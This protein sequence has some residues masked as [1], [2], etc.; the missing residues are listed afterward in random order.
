MNDTIGG[1]TEWWT[2]EGS[3]TSPPCDE[4]VT[5]V[6]LKDR[7]D[8]SPR[9]IALYEKQFGFSA[10]FSHNH[11]R[12]QELGDRNVT[13]RKYVPPKPK[14]K[15]APPPEPDWSY[16]NETGPPYWGDL[17]KAWRKCKTGVAQSPVQIIEPLMD[18]TLPDMHF[19]FKPKVP[20]KVSNDGRTLL[21]KVSHD[22]TSAAACCLHL[23][24]T[25]PHVNSHPAPWWPAP[26]ICIA[27]TISISL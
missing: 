4:G 24:P 13:F 19:D 6:V 2:Y 21:F 26:T 10:M 20:V 1:I 15:P 18:P 27:T 9:Q 17:R 16:Y 12:L 22:V 11:R 14:A 23:A 8:I 3:H 7:E 5:W 25:H